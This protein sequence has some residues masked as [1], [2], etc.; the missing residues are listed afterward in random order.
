MWKVVK[1]SQVWPFIVFL[2][3]AIPVALAVF[4]SVAMLWLLIEQFNG[5]YVWPSATIAAVVA[6]WWLYKK[7]PHE[8]TISFENKVCTAIVLIGVLFWV[9]F[10]AYYTSQHIHTDR[11]PATYAV[12]G[13]W[14][15][16]HDTINIPMEHPFG[17]EDTNVLQT[18]AGFGKSDDNTIFA[19]GAHLLPALLGLVGQITGSVSALLHV[20][21]LFGG[22]A[23]LAVYAFAR[24]IMRQRWALVA[25]AA[26]AVSLPL[27][28]FSRDTYTEP[29]ALTF[30]FSAMT[31]LTLGYQTKQRLL[32]VFAGLVAGA[33][34][35]ARIDTVLSI[36]G[37]V[38][39][40]FVALIITNKQ[41]RKETLYNVLAF[42]MALAAVMFI[43]FLDVKTLS[44]GY[45]I[46][47]SGNIAL[48]MSVFCALL[49]AGSIA[50][51][52]AWKTN[53]LKI[54]DKKT[55]TWR[56]KVFAGLV[57]VICLVLASRPWWME[58][59]RQ[60]SIEL[61]EGLQAAAGLPINGFR[62]Y[63]EIT[64]NWMVWYMGLPLVVLSLL[65]IM[66]IAYRAM[67]SKNIVWVITLAVVFGTALAYF[68]RPS[69]TPDQIWASRRFLPVVMPGIAIIGA[70]ALHWLYE[71]KKLPLKM[72]PRVVTAILAT[73]AIAT[74][75]AT[76]QPFIY[77]RTYV[78]MLD[79]TQSV[80]DVAPK[81]A[82]ILWVGTVSPQNQV[83]PTRAICGFAS[84][85][86]VGKEMNSK[87]SLAK[88]GK[89]ARS[90]GYAPIVGV[91]GS[92]FSLV[93]EQYAQAFTEASAITY[94]RYNHH[95]VQAPKDMLTE[96]R[97]LLLAEI[98]PDGSLVMLTNI[99]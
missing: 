43:G 47:Q 14:L 79:Q 69:I 16:K 3:V 83:K 54:L 44:S 99:N 39:G 94:K 95:L 53:V 96:T 42:F 77:E 57:G 18:S 5:W 65:G 28:Y 51:C 8:K 48:Q 62:D 2:P 85:G 59:T 17:T 90:K 36:I 84:A 20:P 86:Y 10:N 73:L 70:L 89:E 81:N 80:C 31:L 93:P 63:S 97:S 32:W 76:T 55:R 13:I 46:A 67:K 34:Q 22:T 35:L 60:T 91:Y 21:P 66:I 23:L 78:P 64:I 45:F 37:L 29:L 40:V 19:Q 12:A 82:A 24:L 87:A 52:I 26:L 71:R 61:T 15:A 58:G 41:D 11:D 56:A 72:S 92:E 88:L 6:T 9:G 1:K 30:A 38:V 74:P 49:V 68:V 50:T 25:T 75:F 98:A 27:V 4:S 33:G 7:Y